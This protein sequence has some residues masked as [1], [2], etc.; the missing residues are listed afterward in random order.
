MKRALLCSGLLLCLS[1]F[2][3][4]QNSAAT[5]TT[6][7]STT[8]NQNTDTAT[9]NPH[10]ADVRSAQRELKRQ[11][12]DVGDVDGVMGPKT[13]SAVE[14]FQSDKGLTQTGELDAE[15][16]RTLSTNGAKATTSVS[17][18]ATDLG[19]SSKTA[20]H[21]VKTGHPVE[22]GKAEVSGAKDMGKS[23]GHESKSVAKKT[24]NKVKKG[25]DVLSKKIYGTTGDDENAKTP[26][27]K[28]RENSA[29]GESTNTPK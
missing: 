29:V 24:Q 19:R 14:K 15:T 1:S 8:T 7:T 18:A 9:A 12:Y 25:M 22:A 16:L 27:Q 21:D 2:S 26:E 6:T 17:D 23:V 5:T 13:K 10:S 20:A 28:N 3:I 11:G 4:A